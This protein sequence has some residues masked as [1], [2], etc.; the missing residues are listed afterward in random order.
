MRCWRVI[1]TGA[2][3]RRRRPSRLSTGARCRPGPSSR[4]CRRSSIELGVPTIVCDPRELEFEAARLRADG[5]AIDLV[6]RRVLINDILARPADCRALTEAYAARAVCVANTF[7]CKI[8]HKKAFFARADRRAIRG[9][10]SPRRARDRR[11]A[12]PLDAP[13]RRRRTTRDGRHMDLMPHIRTNRHDLVLKPNDE[14]GGHGVTLGWEADDDALGRDPDEGAER[15]SGRVGRAGA[16]SRAPRA[17]PQF[18]AGEARHSATCWWT[19][20]RIS[21]AGKLAGFLTRLS[22]TGLAN[23][24]SGGGQVPSFVVRPAA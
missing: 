20:R 24:T 1:A 17:F 4:S 2:A 10:V 15:R 9:P 7:R 12:H 23:V 11:S 6:Y 16:D 3:R 19:A 13:G 18:A 5:R 22:A 21:S 14:Y 8:P